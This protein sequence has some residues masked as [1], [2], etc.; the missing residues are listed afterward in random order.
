MSRVISSISLLFFAAGFL[1]GCVGIQTKITPAAPPS[2]KEIVGTWKSRNNFY[3]IFDDAD[4]SFS[5]ADSAK[6]AEAKAGPHGSFTL[7]DSEL[8]LLESA[9]SEVCPGIEARFQAEIVRDGNLRLTI[10]DDPCI[11]RVEG[12]FQGGQGGNVFIEFRRIQ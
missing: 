7:V 11:Y 2:P 9:D 12:V 10:I 3:L 1:T 8:H 4:G 5:F 6:S